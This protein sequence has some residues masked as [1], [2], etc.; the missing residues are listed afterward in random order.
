MYQDIIG[1]NR[2]RTPFRVRG[3]D[4]LLRAYCCSYDEEHRQGE[5]KGGSSV[6][7]SGD[8][9]GGGGGMPPPRTKE[10]VLR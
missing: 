9:G 7:G 6:D 1:R 2:V 3:V 4:Q 10:Y 5:S 8:G